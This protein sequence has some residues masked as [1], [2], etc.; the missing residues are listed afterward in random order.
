LILLKGMPKLGGVNNDWI[1]A[2]TDKPQL[3]RGGKTLEG[4]EKNCGPWVWLR[5]IK[6]RRNFR[7]K[8]K[9]GKRGDPRVLLEKGT[10]GGNRLIGG[11]KNRVVCRGKRN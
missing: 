1:A 5:N 7:Q 9:R 3:S 4:A 11:G 10:V 2:V 8:K 6:D